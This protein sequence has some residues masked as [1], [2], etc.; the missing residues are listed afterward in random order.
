MA[1]FGRP[2]K[3]FS[4]I[5]NAKAE[6]FMLAFE[7]YKSGDF[8]AYFDLVSSPEV[9]R[10]ITGR[11]LSKPEA[12][13]KFESILQSG[14]AD[15]SL[16]YFK[17]LMHQKG[18]MMQIGD[19]KLVLYKKDPD[20]LEVGYLLKKP[21]WGKG[22][23][24]RVCRGMLKLANDVH[25]E[26]NIIGIIDPE[27]QASRRILEKSGFKTIFQGIEDG[28]PTEKLLLQRKPVP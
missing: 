23:G 10:F 11:G 5:R 20:M 4:Y 13:D 22:L 17:V 27:N 28:L 9:M 14:G 19:C 1:G 8:K 12:R 7:K 6:N 26:K 21:Y 24:S 25:P 18:E 2:Q 3:G 16:G 15:A